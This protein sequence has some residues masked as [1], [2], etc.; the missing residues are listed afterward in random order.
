MPKGIDWSAKRICL[1]SKCFCFSFARSLIRSVVFISYTFCLLR[2]QP[3][4][5]WFHLCVRLSLSLVS[6]VKTKRCDAIF[7]SRSHSTGHQ[8]RLACM[9]ETDAPIMWYANSC[10]FFLAA[11]LLYSFVCSSFSARFLCFNFYR[12]PCF[13]SLGPR[14]LGCH[15]AIGF[16]CCFRLARHARAPTEAI[17]I[18]KKNRSKQE[19]NNFYSLRAVC[20]PNR[21]R[22][23]LFFGVFFRDPI[24]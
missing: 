16:N 3:F 19:T 1:F 5:R 24:L 18:L 15:A 17:I 8:R 12:W 13:V 14:F 21:A 10:G 4:I 7:L 20:K 11:F 9:P 2:I 23:S 22:T 6:S